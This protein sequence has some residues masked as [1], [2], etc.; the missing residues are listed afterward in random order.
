MSFAQVKD[1]ATHLQIINTLT[2]REIANIDLEHGHSIKT[3]AHRLIIIK[4]IENKDEFYGCTEIKHVRSIADIVSE[5]YVL[6]MRMKGSTSDE[7]LTA[8][9]KVLHT[10]TFMIGYLYSEQIRTLL[11]LLLDGSKMQQA[12][13]NTNFMMN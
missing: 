11:A 7:L 8:A 9:A 13:C 2:D 6:S 10:A 12:I 5:A 3:I 1:I 4:I